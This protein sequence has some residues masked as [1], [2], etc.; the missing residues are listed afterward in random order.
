MK[1]VECIECK[2][3]PC[4]GIDKSGYIMP[5]ADLDP[6]KV[7]VVMISEAPPE[8]PH[9]YFY[10][11]GD[12]FYL[13]T[14]LQAFNDAGISVSSIREILDLGFYLTTAVKCKKTQYGISAQTVKNCSLV[15]EKELALFPNIEVYMLMVEL[16][17]R[18]VEKRSDS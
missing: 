2:N 6:E 3:F 8:D 13:R 14:T 1:P 11:P 10:A 7:K 12:P 4:S 9:D 16:P 18:K 15:L 5:A 17:D